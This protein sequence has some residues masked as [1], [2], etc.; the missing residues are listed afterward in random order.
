MWA[1]YVLSAEGTGLLPFHPPASFVVLI[2]I[3]TFTG[4]MVAGFVVTAVTQGH[5]G[6]VRLLRRI[7][8]WRVGLVWY[9]FVFLG[10][11]AV[12]MPGG[13]AYKSSTGL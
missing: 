7:V 8:Q 13:R 11:G 12:A 10:L 4:P 9:A 3:G 1:L 2:G 6:V 5:D